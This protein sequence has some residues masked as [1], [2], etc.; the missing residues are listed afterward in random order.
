MSVQERV[1]VISSLDTPEWWPDSTPPMPGRELSGPHVW[2]GEDMAQTDEWIYALSD[3]ELS[4]I[5]EALNGVK[6]RA[7]DLLAVDKKDFPLPTFGPVITRSR[8]S[9]LGFPH[10]FA[11]GSCCP[12]Q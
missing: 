8:S 4:E 2:Y 9:F 11:T 10:S 5:N 12:G 7:D 6:N 3:S 1:G